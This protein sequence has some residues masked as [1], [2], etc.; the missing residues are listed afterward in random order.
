MIDREWR[1][2]EEILAAFCPAG[3]EYVVAALGGGN[4]N[5]T[6]LLR[7]P[8]RRLVL[9]RIAEHV[10]VDPLVVINNFVQV[11]SY[12]RRRAAAENLSFPVASPEPAVTGGMAV[13]DRRGGWWRAQSYL[14]HTAVKML[15]EAAA[16]QVGRVLALFH[17]LASGLEGQLAHDPLP[18]FHDLSCYLQRFDVVQDGQTT[19]SDEQ[20]AHCLAVIAR[21]RTQALLFHEALEQDI[22]RPQLVHGDPKLENFIGDTS[23]RAC[24]LF[25]LDTVRLGLLHHDLGDCL[26]SCCNV[27]G[28]EGES[29]VQFDGERCRAILEGYF[30]LPQTCWTV[31]QRELIYDGLLLICFELGLRFF[32][33]YLQGNCYFKVSDERQNLRR[34]IRQ[35]QLVDELIRREGEL[36][37]LIMTASGG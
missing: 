25:D 10:F 24:G 18:G 35:F 4:I 5:D 12:L 3:E 9:Q 6:Y 34:A 27:G 33:D 31:P 16:R 13:R 17:H 26:R 36:R 32:T 14:E 7:G 1:P 30:F 28:E 37:Q 20:N 15:D 11:S 29:R 19:A 2:P 21:L 23:S 22:L 8:Q